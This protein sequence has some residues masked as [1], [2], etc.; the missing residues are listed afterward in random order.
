MPAVIRAGAAGTGAETDLVEQGL[1][2]SIEPFIIQRFANQGF[3]YIRAAPGSWSAGANSQAHLADHVIVAFQP[4]CKINNGQRHTLRTHNAL[5][6][7]SL[8]SLGKAHIE[9]DQQFL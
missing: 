8:S 9:T 7:G 6:A 3:F 5:E 1:Y 4:D 2:R